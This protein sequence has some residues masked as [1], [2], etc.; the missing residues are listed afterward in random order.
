MGGIKPMIKNN[1]VKKIG[2]VNSHVKQYLDYYCHLD[3]APGY[4]I[5]L[6]G[7]WGIGKTWF[8]KNYQKSNE[9]LR[10]LYV[11]LYGISELSEIEYAFFQQLHPILSSKGMV[12]FGRFMKG[13]LRGTLK[14]DLNN[15]G[16]S[17]GNLAISVPDLEISKHLSDTSKCILV[18]DDIERCVIDISQILGYINYFVEQKDM[19]AI[20]IADED[21]LLS[22]KQNA[23]YSYKDIKEKL[24]GKTFSINH[25]I[26]DVL[27]NYISDISKRHHKQFQDENLN[28][29]KST[30]SESRSENLR[31]L[32]Q[33][34]LDFDRIYQKLSDEA[35][36]NQKALEA[37]LKTLVF[38]SIELKSNSFTSEEIF[39]VLKKYS[40]FYFPVTY[41][42]SE[43]AKDPLFDWESE[44]Y[45]K[46]SLFKGDTFFP[47]LKW[48]QDFFDDGLIDLNE[49]DENINSS[50]YFKNENTLDWIRLWHYHD[51]SDDEFP[52][53][54]KEV[55]D[56]LWGYKYFDIGEICHIVGIL[57]FFSEAGLYSKL[58]KNEIV[59]KSKESIRYMFANQL[60]DFSTL[61]DM[62]F[63][64]GSYKSLGILERESTEY[65]DFKKYVSGT[66]EVFLKNKIREVAQEIP[67]IMRENIWKF[68]FIICPDSIYYTD[69]SITTYY[70]KPILNC[71]DPSLFINSFFE[72]KSLDQITLLQSLQSRYGFNTIELLDELQW[73]EKIRELL[74]NKVN[75]R[76]GKISSY[77]LH[78]YINNILNPII[79]NLKN[80]SPKDS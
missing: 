40:E 11:S 69:E 41:E 66:Y 28:I 23:T 8:I 53:L 14:I 58:E 78:E 73:L 21:K 49:L 64:Y 16:A 24:I 72:L 63:D 3:S 27:S 33:I 55:S 4:A 48:W 80:Y 45:N 56:K 12:L 67:T 74:A 10:I 79:E 17:D 9:T 75:E 31:I 43:R 20:L 44:V 34:I 35:K 51:L 47:S 60:I 15:D 6:K 61:Q 71:I 52:I 29:I 65:K 1:K 62:H 59:E 68:I 7:K 37:L 30:F 39:G 19:K 42:D 38:L 76:V 50:R 77:V 36:N 46:Y 2:S 57:L 13:I 32:R 54:I 25:A 26:D 18:F 70:D 5:L 22:N